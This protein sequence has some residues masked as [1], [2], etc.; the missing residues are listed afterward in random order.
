MGAGLLLSG[1]NLPEGSLA[2]ASGAGS[3]V[4]CIDFASLVLARPLIFSFSNPSSSRL[5]HPFIVESCACQINQ[6]WDRVLTSYPPHRQVGTTLAGVPR[7][8]RWIARI[9]RYR[10]IRAIH[11]DTT[12]F[13]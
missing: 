3:T 1:N 12:C 8:F 6:G 7:R 10:S 2:A 4:Y 9:D 11:L 13:S 5:A